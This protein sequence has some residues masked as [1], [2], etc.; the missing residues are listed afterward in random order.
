MHKVCLYISPAPNPK[1]G[2][3]VRENNDK[4]IIETENVLPWWM[5]D[6]NSSNNKA[7]YCKRQNK[8]VVGLP[9]NNDE[10]FKNVKKSFSSTTFKD[11]EH[12]KSELFLKKTG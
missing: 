6:R 10:N 4:N 7:I 1:P 12:K 8:I 3:F 11:P 9:L 5:K 2:N